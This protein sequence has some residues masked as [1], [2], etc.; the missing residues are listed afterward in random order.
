MDTVAAE[1]SCAELLKVLADQTRLAV[2][3]QL[4]DGAKHVSQLNQSLQVEKTLLSHHL[5]VLRESGIVH[6]Q[7]EGKA[8]LYR[9]SPAVES[10]R[11]GEGLD[12]GCCRIVFD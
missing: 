1:V 11:R 2:V 5:K 7:R 3:R 9:L 12:L 4:M 6:A 10:K 8:M